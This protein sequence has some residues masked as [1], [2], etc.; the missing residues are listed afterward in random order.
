MP[1]YGGDP[2]FNNIHGEA[3]LE[4]YVR[5][6]GEAVTRN[7]TQRE[8]ALWTHMVALEL[9]EMKLAGEAGT[10]A[11]R[12]INEGYDTVQ[13]LAEL[14]IEG[15]VDAGMRKGNATLLMGRVSQKCTSS[16]GEHSSKK[17]EG[18]AGGLTWQ[19]ILWFGGDYA[20]S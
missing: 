19:W 2:D 4:Y 9:G 12:L 18:S 11:K 5:I 20:H 1:R 7:I 6:E 3:L 14:D 17:G 15:L 13:G 10:Y 16:G 8:L